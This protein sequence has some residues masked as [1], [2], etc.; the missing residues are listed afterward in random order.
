VASTYRSPSLCS[1]VVGHYRGI[2]VIVDITNGWRTGRSAGLSPKATIGSKGV[3]RQMDGLV[4][5]RLHSERELD[6]IAT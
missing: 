6:E 4:R 2:Q 1:T 5:A 3:S